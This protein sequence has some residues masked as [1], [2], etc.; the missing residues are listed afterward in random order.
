MMFRT[1]EGRSFSP[2]HVA[3]L[4]H[5]LHTSNLKF[6]STSATR[7][8]ELELALHTGL[9]R[10]ELY[11]A[12]WADVDFKRGVL[13]VPCEKG[14][15]TSQVPL[16]GAAKWALAELRRQHGDSEFVCDGSTNPG[17]SMTP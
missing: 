4:R 9:R 14:N 16:N 15:R 11:G 3:T 10:S 17:G 7:L 13:T 5:F 2:A 6:D 12:R 1:V 8:V